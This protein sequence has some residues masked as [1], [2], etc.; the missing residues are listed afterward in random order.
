MQEN[1]NVEYAI[2]D[3]SKTKHVP[4]N[5][6]SVQHLR[7]E[8]RRSLCESYAH[9]HNTYTANMLSEL[10]PDCDDPDISKYPQT[11]PVHTMPQIRKDDTTKLRGKNEKQTNEILYSVVSAIQLGSLPVPYFT[12]HM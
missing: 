5:V 2:S 8:V 1:Y 11:Y 9:H 4:F 12:Q 3:V 6:S 10:A 7:D